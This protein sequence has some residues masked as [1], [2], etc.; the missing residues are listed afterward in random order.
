LVCSFL[1]VVDT[2]R[3]NPR[4]YFFAAGGCGN[5]NEMTSRNWLWPVVLGRSTLL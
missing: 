1:Y 2:V 5:R 3:R 4:R